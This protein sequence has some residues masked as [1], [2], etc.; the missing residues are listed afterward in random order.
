[1]TWSPPTTTRYFRP[2]TFGCERICE[3]ITPLIA[4]TTAFAATAL[5][6][7]AFNVAYAL[8]TDAKRSTERMPFGK[9]SAAKEAQIVERLR[10]QR[11]RRAREI[12]SGVGD[13][14]LVQRH[15]GREGG[16]ELRP[17]RPVDDEV[18]VGRQVAEVER[19]HR[20]DRGCR[21]AV[22]VDVRG[23]RQVRQVEGIVEQLG[24]GGG[25]IVGLERVAD[26]E[27]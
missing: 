24:R 2:A 14:R 4:W 1:M 20:S 17:S 27:D 8:C 11:P 15:R 18:V 22:V 25:R 13:G 23:G 19:H 5:P 7:V 10:G 26:R 16:P 12:D 9:P 3:S 21:E 6:G